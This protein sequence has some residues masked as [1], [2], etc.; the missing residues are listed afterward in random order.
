MTRDEITAAIISAR[1]RKG[2][3]WQELADALGRPVVWST[4]ALLGQHPFPPDLAAKVVELLELPV[5]AAAVLSVV[6]H[7]GAGPAAIP[8]SDPTIYRFYE[9]LQVYG[10]ALKELIHEQFGDGIM[11]AINF[12]MDLGRTEHDGADHVVVTFDGK[13]LP[14][15]W[16][17]D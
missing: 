6:P 17:S 5:D 4:A 3:T 14:Y 9:A 1:T 13:F 12:R 10:P 16:P 11:S 2:L 8:P 7:R 15:A